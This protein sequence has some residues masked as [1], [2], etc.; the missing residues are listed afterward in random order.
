MR[1]Y[2][3]TQIEKR[4]TDIKRLE[5][6]RQALAHQIE[7]I[8]IELCTYADMLQR[9]EAESDA[10]PADEERVI[11]QMK[12]CKT[13]ANCHSRCRRTLLASHYQR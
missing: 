9:L 7:T 6:E 2:L 1:D 11:K 12:V 4:R 13:L 5:T 3:V 8:N 10:A